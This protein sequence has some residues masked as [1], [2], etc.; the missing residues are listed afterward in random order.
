MHRIPRW[1]RRTLVI[2]ALI[3]LGLA[4]SR[5]ARVEGLQWPIVTTKV[6]HVEDGDT[7]EVRIAGKTERI[8]MVG[9]DT[10]ETVDPRKPIQCYGPEASDH[11][12]QVLADQMV[13]LTSDTVSGDRDIYGRLLRYVTLADGSDYGQALLSEGYAREYDYKGQRYSKRSV[14]RAAQTEAKA[15]KRGLWSPETCKGGR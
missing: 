4:L 12:K 1:V 11:T 5:L 2:V 9:I 3:A 7:F 10:P 6:L 14:Y 8:R 13:T 15:A